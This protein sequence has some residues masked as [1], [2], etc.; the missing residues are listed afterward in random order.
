MEGL[1]K[2]LMLVA[3]AFGSIVPVTV[4]A[5]D[6]AIFVVSMYTAV[7][8]AEAVSMTW[9][10]RYENVPLDPLVRLFVYW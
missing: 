6:T 7:K 1:G 2:I 5:G 10:M 4:Q 8:L 9:R 3:P